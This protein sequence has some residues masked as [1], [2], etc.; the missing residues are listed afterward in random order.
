MRKRLS[1]VLAVVLGLACHGGA[2]E[3]AVPARIRG[4]VLVL[5]G[6]RLV[7]AGPGGRPVSVALAPDYGVTALAA[8]RPEAVAPG[9]YIGTVAT[10]AGGGVL[11][12]RE[13]HIF[14]DNLR[15]A[16]AGERPFEPGT[17]SVVVSG[18]VEQGLTDGFGGTVTLS[19]PGGVAVVLVPAGTPV[20][21]LAPGN[22]AML[23]PGAHVVVQP[24]ARPDGT[25]RADHV[26]VGVDGLVP[27]I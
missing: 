8:A 12:A 6:G 2:A 24:D 19:H 18:T 23:M 26:I 21:V 27:Q 1:A 13:I 9:R 25:L 7:V 17:G 14:P 5:D 15:G 10:R 4:T 11:R 22:R 3:S 16:G 20:A